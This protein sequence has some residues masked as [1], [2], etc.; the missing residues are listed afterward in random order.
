MKHILFVVF[1][2]AMVSLP[3]SAATPLCGFC[4]CQN[5][6]TQQFPCTTGC[7]NPY[8]ATLNV[9]AAT[10]TNCR[11][12]VQRIFYCSSLEN[13]CTDYVSYW[14]NSGICNAVC[15]PEGCQ[16]AGLQVPERVQ[17]MAT[18]KPTCEGAYKR[19]WDM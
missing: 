13:G 19:I 16:V 9:L 8:M 12:P 3:L 10:S 1:A 17:Q 2:M 15:G 14:Q 5:L 11:V 18:L 7:S 6:T 4:F